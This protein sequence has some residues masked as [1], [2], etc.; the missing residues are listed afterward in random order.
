[1]NKRVLI[2]GG[3]GFV[4]HWLTK[5]H[6]ID[7][8]GNGWLVN[9]G[10]GDYNTF[11][12]MNHQWDLIIHAAPIDPCDVLSVAKRDNARVLYVSSGAVYHPEN[13]TEYRQNKIR[14][15]QECLDSG[16]DVV[17]AR[18]EI[19]HTAFGSGRDCSSYSGN[20]GRL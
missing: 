14:W 10:S 6:P 8:S 20:H 9:I 18:R 2:T 5:N 7:Q 13:N 19:Q 1:M 17:I 3:T 4:G 16:V 15:E 11:E 12:W